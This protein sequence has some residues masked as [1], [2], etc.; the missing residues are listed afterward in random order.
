MART[1]PSLMC[2]FIILGAGCLGGRGNPLVGTG[3]LPLSATNPFLGVN[4][5]L[6]EQLSQGRNL[7]DIK[8]HQTYIAHRIM[9]TD[10]RSEWVV[11]G[12]FVMARRQYVNLIKLG[13]YPGSAPVFLVNGR[14][15]NFRLPPTPTP[16]STP[17]SITARPRSHSGMRRAQR[18]RAVPTKR[19]GVQTRGIYSKA[20]GA[21]VTSPTPNSDQR[22]LSMSRPTPIP[23]EVLRRILGASASPI[24]APPIAA[25]ETA[26][27]STPTAQSSAAPLEGA[28]APADGTS[29]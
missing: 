12:P 21:I 23:V 1:I 29:H 8:L 17:H 10:G 13:I 4:Q 22:A 2:A 18:R 5:F 9:E 16:T 15:T 26:P 14:L 20:S 11:R 25:P 28:P 24:A 6:G 7:R 27:A 19:E 3:P